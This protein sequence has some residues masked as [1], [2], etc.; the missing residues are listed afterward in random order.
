MARHPYALATLTVALLIHSQLLHSS[1]IHLQVIL[2]LVI[3]VVNW[4]RTYAG[5][6]LAFTHAK[7]FFVL[8]KVFILIVNHNFFECIQGFL[9]GLTVL[10]EPS[11]KP[12]RILFGAKHRYHELR[13][14]SRA[15]SELFQVISIHSVPIYPVNILHSLDVFGGLILNKVSNEQAFLFGLNKRVMAFW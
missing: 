1:I 15:I 7:S 5:A 10:T 3:A 6:V 14:S 9:K 11:L 2:A 8:E 4:V 13:R 12:H